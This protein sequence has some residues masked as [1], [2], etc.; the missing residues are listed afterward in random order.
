ML[1]QHILALATSLKWLPAD[2]SAIFLTDH[3]QNRVMSELNGDINK[4]KHAATMLLT[5]PGTPFLYYGEEIRLKKH[6]PDENLRR[7][8][9]WSGNADAGFSTVSP[10]R[11][12][13]VDFP[14]KNVALPK[15]KIPQTHCSRI[16]AT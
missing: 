10:W 13:A 14:E 8:M 16:I 11:T 6:K 4:A 2:H 7:P 5:L 1:I 9:Q 12:P 3:D 15:M